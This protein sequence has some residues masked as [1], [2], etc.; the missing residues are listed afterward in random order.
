VALNRRALLTGSSAAVLG[1]LTT[2]L[3]GGLNPQARTPTSPVYPTGLNRIPNVPVVTHE[4]QAV[5]FYDALVKDRIVTLNFMYTRCTDI[6]LP[7]TSNLT[8]VQAL[9]GERVGRDIFMYSITL[10]P[11]RDT[12]EALRAHAK[13]FGVRPGWKFLTGR[14]EDI[15]HLRVSLGFTD[16]DPAIDRIDASHTGI[17]RYG[18]DALQRW[19]GTPGLGRPE[20]IAHAIVD[21]MMPAGAPGVSPI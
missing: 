9:L 18:N 8:R 21:T 7:M 17:L 4:G 2:S 20:W 15:E 16:P 10:Q 3:L 13:L 19:A 1:G 11:Q 6:C 12:V 5:R 14:P